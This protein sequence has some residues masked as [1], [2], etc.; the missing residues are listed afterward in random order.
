MD[1]GGI[2][3]LESIHGLFER[4]QIRAQASGQIFEDDVNGF[5]TTTVFAPYMVHDPVFR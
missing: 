2:D 1:G 4:L 3:T 5:P